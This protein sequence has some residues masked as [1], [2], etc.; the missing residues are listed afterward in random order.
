MVKLKVIS[1][2]H[3]E[4]FSINSKLLTY[5]DSTKMTVLMRTVCV[6]VCVLVTFTFSSTIGQQLAVKRGAECVSLPSPIIASHKVRPMWPR[7]GNLLK[8]VDGNWMLRSSRQNHAPL[9]IWHAW[10]I[11]VWICPGVCKPSSQLWVKQFQ[12]FVDGEGNSIIKPLL[13]C[14]IPIYGNGFGR[15]PRG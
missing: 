2:E 5:K 8:V 14:G 1:G 10:P 4:R 12:C 3:L 7:Y 6:C 11:S 9:D 15:K 13:P